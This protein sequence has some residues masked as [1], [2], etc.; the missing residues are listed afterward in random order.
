MRA[1]VE[2]HEHHGREKSE[3]QREQER[4]RTRALHATGEQQIAGPAQ[5]D[6]FKLANWSKVVEYFQKL[7]A[8]S[9]RIMLTEAGRTTLGR[10]FVYAVI[11][12]PENLKRLNYYKAINDKLADPREIRRSDRVARALIKKGKT[13]VAITHGIHST[14][15]GST[16]SSTLIAHRLVTNGIG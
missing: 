4:P 2:R 13:F 3:A 8:A 14:E 7:D 11:S 5:G 1:G 10:P 6:D 12:S 16:L 15:V 9:D